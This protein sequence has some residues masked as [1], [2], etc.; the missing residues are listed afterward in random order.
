MHRI[1]NMCIRDKVFYE[2]LTYY[3]GNGESAEHWMATP[4][5]LLGGECPD[6]VIKTGGGNRLLT[7]LL[8]FSQKKVVK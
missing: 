1:E 7:Y 3:N 5:L 2:A 4:N 6:E 8:E